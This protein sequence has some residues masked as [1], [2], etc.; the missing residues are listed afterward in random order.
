MRF[1]SSLVLLPIAAAQAPFQIEQSS[2]PTAALATV[3]SVRA[4]YEA[5][6]SAQ[7]AFT[8]F[9]KELCSITVDAPAATVYAEA[10]CDPIVLAAEYLRA[11]ATPFWYSDLPSDLKGYVNSIASA[12]ASMLQKAVSGGQRVQASVKVMGAALAAGVVVMLML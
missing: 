6:L 7:P 5:S 1:L 3:T 2:Y 12:E 8:S 11:T 4:S 9:A 10:G